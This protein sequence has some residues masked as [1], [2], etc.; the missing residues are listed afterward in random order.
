MNKTSIIIPTYNGGALLR[1]C[2]A[3]IR[4]HTPQPHEI[5]V[6]DNGSVDGTAHLCRQEEVTFISLAHNA[7]FP[8]ACNCGLQLA[9]GDALVLLNNDVLVTRNWLNNML[10]CLSSSG[11]I[12]LVGPMTNYASGRQQLD[13]PFTHVEDMAAR[14]NDPD[15]SKWRES[16]RIVGLCMLFKRELMERI[17]LL[18]ERFSPGHY[19]DDDYCW[20]A[21]MAGYRC[22]IAGDVFVFHHGSASFGQQAEAELQQLIAVNRDKFIAKWGAAPPAE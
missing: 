19:E 11:D 14:H 18:D 16:T 10:A 7:G 22:V 8:A 3:S 5:I 4:A 15:P 13:E 1:E 17:G 2:I 12:G 9:S 20:R 21:R 6:V